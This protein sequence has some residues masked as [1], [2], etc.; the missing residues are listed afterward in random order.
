M[1]ALAVIALMT[2]C[3]C[4]QV[5]EHHVPAAVTTNGTTDGN[6]TAGAKKAPDARAPGTGATNDGSCGAA[7][8]HP[9]HVPSTM[10]VHLHD[11]KSGDEYDL[12]VSLSS[13]EQD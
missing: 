9:L 1:K 4:W 11:V 3:N 6:K 12:R 5:T 13:S 7:A 10:A 8:A 2:L